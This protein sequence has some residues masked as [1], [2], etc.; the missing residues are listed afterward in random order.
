MCGVALDPT[1]S[2][3]SEADGL[4]QEEPSAFRVAPTE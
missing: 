2:R 1:R 4:R 3:R